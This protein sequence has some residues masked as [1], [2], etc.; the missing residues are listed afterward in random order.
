MTAVIHFNLSIKNTQ[1]DA[2]PHARPL[3]WPPA[4]SIDQRYR[5]SRSRRDGW[6]DPA[7]PSGWWIQVSSFDLCAAH[8]SISLR[9]GWSGYD[10]A[11][12]LE[13][14]RLPSET[15]ADQVD[16]GESS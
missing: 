13:G 7:E 9:R 15:K 3:Y 10:T 16:Q 14:M 6:S 2:S 8:M 4:H 1:K 5:A 12:T 11:G